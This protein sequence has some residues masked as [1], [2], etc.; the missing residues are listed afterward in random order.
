MIDS[1]FDMTFIV[2]IQLNDSIIVA[3]DNKKVTISEDGSLHLSNESISKMFPWQK[4]IITGTGEY[5][6][7]SRC[8]QIFNHLKELPLNIYL[9]A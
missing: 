6:V 8:V 2:A 5:L 9:I 4:G 7:I 1:T 3:S